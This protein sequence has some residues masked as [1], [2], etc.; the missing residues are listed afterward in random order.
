MDVADTCCQEIDSQISYH[1][2]FLG[3]R[4]LAHTDHA[5]F[6]AADGTNLCFQRHVVLRADLNQFFRLGN[7]LFD[8][9]VRTVEHNGGKACLYAFQA[10]FIA[11]VVKMKGNR[12]RDVQLFDHTL[13]HT[14]D[15]FVSSHI[16]AGSLGY[17]KDNRRIVFLCCQQDRLGPLKVIDVELS[18]CIMSCFCLFQHF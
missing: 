18:Y 5:V 17:A 9:I 11:A 15:C 7:V 3:I 14:Y 16:L 8:G 4:A 1:L 2:A 12:N 10:S 13:N 6:L